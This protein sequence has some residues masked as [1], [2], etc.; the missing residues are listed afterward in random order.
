VRIVSQIMDWVTTPYTIYL[1]LRDTGVERPVKI[2]A[3][4]GLAIIFAYVISPVDLIPDFVPFAGWLDDLIVVPIG[5]ALLRK[6]T[7]GVDLVEKRT[8]AQASVRRFMIWTVVSLVVFILVALAWL[9][10]VVY[11]IAR[12]V[13]H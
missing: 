5:L 10:L 13:M 3:A 9:G 6:F 2:R 12:L 7:P 4:I 8:R 1:V 11:V